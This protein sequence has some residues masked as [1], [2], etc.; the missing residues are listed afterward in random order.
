MRNSPFF[1]VEGRDARTRSGL[2]ASYFRHDRSGDC[3]TAWTFL[4]GGQPLHYDDAGRLSGA[5]PHEHPLDLIREDHPDDHAVDDFSNLIR[6]KMA[7][8]RAKGRSGWFDRTACTDQS[9]ARMFVAHMSKSNAGNL[10]DLATIAMML[11]LRGADPALIGSACP[12]STLRDA[13]SKSTVWLRT[14]SICAN[15]DPDTAQTRQPPEM[16]SLAE[17]I[18][19]N[20]SLMTAPEGG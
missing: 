16:P 1:P 4:V 9:L 3:T 18:A 10:V 8:S 13:L 12:V 11:H 14:L 15:S 2:L 19:I 20:T 17:Q 7:R 5:G 6:D